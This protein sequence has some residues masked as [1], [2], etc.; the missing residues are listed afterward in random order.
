MKSKLRFPFSKH[1]NEIILE[2]NLHVS[3]AEHRNSAWSYSYDLNL[4]KI[5]EEASPEAIESDFSESE[6]ENKSTSRL[7]PDENLEDDL[8]FESSNQVHEI[9]ASDH[10]KGSVTEPLSYH[11][12]ENT[13]ETSIYKSSDN[14]L[15]ATVTE[16]EQSVDIVKCLQLSDVQK[17]PPWLV[18]IILRFPDKMGN[19]WDTNLTNIKKMVP[20]IQTMIMDYLEQFIQKN[21]LPWLQKLEQ[22]QMEYYR[23][24]TKWKKEIEFLKQQNSWLKSE[25]QHVNRVYKKAVEELTNLKKYCS[26][27]KSVQVRNVDINTHPKTISVVSE[28]PAL[29]QQEYTVEKERSPFKRKFAQELF[30]NE[31][32]LGDSKEKFVLNE[33]MKL[34]LL[35]TDF[36]KKVDFEAG[37]RDE[38][39]SLSEKPKG[40]SLSMIKSPRHWHPLAKTMNCISNENGFKEA[41]ASF[42]KW[43]K[44]GWRKTPL[45]EYENF[46][47]ITE[48]SSGASLKQSQHKQSSEQYKVKLQR[49]PE[50]PNS[51]ARKLDNSWKPRHPRKATNA[52]NERVVKDDKKEMSPDLEKISKQSTVRCLMDFREYQ[53]SSKRL[54]RNQSGYTKRSIWL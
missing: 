16:T 43:P 6:V 54:D 22:L 40:L 33:P 11:S 13:Q 15:S 18:K 49:K 19:S 2:D 45:S 21:A 36:Q 53:G 20:Q 44:S 27:N 42:L 8:I 37:S 1:K 7:N 4:N 50:T 52:L 47:P 30:P 12:P 31:K 32:I 23:E 41:C 38:A 51:D 28:K 9:A 25:L 29:S 39:L 35:N 48:K 46:I 10:L 3:S 17:Q 5:C 24:K 34:K 14:L 26:K